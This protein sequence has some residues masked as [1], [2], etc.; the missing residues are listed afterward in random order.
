[1][2]GP[3]CEAPIAFEELAAHWNGELD[4]A[5]SLEIDEHVF[6][7][8]RCEAR[9]AWVAAL[10]EGVVSTLREGGV[11]FEASGALLNCMARDRLLTRQ[12]TLRPGETVACTVAPDD[13]FLVA[14]LL[15]PT[16]AVSSMAGDMRVDLELRQGDGPRQRLE[17]VPVDVTRSCVVATLPAHFTHADPSEL[18]RL[19]LFRI[20]EDADAEEELAAYT[21]DHTAMHE[22]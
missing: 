11:A 2:N 16:G 17:D 3:R 18:R 6:S 9:L 15:L 5:R 20:D 7:C 14:I 4:E 13:D 10:G 12:Y 8:D 22:V 1:M 19:R 21:L